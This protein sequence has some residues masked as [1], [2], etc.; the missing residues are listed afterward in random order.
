MSRQRT[1]G[2]HATTQH[3]DRD[4]GRTR[5]RSQQPGSPGR[6]EA[7][8]P[9]AR[10]P[11]HE[12]PREVAASHGCASPP[13]RLHAT[14][15]NRPA[16]APESSQRQQRAAPESPSPRADRCGR[17][18]DSPRLDASGCGRGAQQPPLRCV[19]RTALRGPCAGARQGWRALPGYACATGTRGSWPGA[20]YSAGT[21][22]C[23][24]VTP[25]SRCQGL[26]H[27]PS[28]PRR[29]DRQGLERFS[30]HHSLRK[31]QEATVAV[32]RPHVTA[33]HRTGSNRHP[34][35]AI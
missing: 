13:T 20:G 31:G 17:Q 34:L 2:A 4:V 23:S 27:A 11:A 8:R 33:I 18:R 16:Q 1:W 24:P 32:K 26:E 6:R 25:R 14:L 30:H 7:N 35:Q 29:H 15:R 28:T 19:R 10:R 3:P 22:A 12:R 21:S 5:I 9:A